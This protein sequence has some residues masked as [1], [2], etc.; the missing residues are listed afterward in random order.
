M[1]KRMKI[2]AHIPCFTDETCYT[3]NSSDIITKDAYG[4]LNLVEQSF[5]KIAYSALSTRTM[6]HTYHGYSYDTADHS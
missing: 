4:D 2:F 1:T 3:P 6:K 5:L